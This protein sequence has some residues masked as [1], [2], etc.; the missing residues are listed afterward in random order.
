MC[1]LPFAAFRVNCS[2][3]SDHVGMKLSLSDIGR[4]KRVFFF[5]VCFLAL[6]N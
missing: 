6:K 2:F 1:R 3:V 4:S 5:V